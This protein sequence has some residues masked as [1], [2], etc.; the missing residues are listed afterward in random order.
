M[1]AGAPVVWRSGREIRELM[2]EYYTDRK[3]LP[4]AAS[5]NWRTQPKA[6]GKSVF[7]HRSNNCV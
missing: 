5:G 3:E 6:P 7:A 1:F 4:T 2:V